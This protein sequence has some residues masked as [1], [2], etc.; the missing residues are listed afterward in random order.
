MDVMG[1]IRRLRS[2]VDGMV[3]R[4][5]INRV[6][7]AL[8]TQRLQLTM[9]DGEVE[10]DVE[11]LQPFGLS[12]VPPASAE[13]ITLAVGGDR[14]HTVGICANDP[15]TRPRGG[16]PGTGGLYT[17]TGWKVFIDASG[18]VHVGAETGADFVALAASV[19]T[20]LNDIRTKFDAHTHI[21]TATVGATATPGV[22][23]IPAPPMGPAATVAATKLKAT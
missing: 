22:L 4:A 16:L 11:H 21:T 3:S 2:R 23:A 12:F 10:D 17:A 19:L 18:V 20:Q 15:S 9:L 13:L 1:A 8:R 6:S 7:D 14:A 5:V